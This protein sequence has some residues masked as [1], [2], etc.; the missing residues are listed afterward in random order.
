LEKRPAP[1]IEEGS[2]ISL[3]EEEKEKMLIRM[4]RAEKLGINM[5]K[6]D[7]E[8]A[9]EGMEQEDADRLEAW[10]YIMRDQEVPHELEQRILMRCSLDK[11]RKIT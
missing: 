7:R 1:H 10:L 4:Q 8:E 5:S 9:D 3:T 11:P 6:F 2:L